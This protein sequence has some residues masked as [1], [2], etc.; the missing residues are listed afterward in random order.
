MAQWAKTINDGLRCAG[1]AQLRVTY[2]RFALGRSS[3]KSPH[4]LRG[5]VCPLWHDAVAPS[6]GWLVCGLVLDLLGCELGRRNLELCCMARKR[7]AIVFCVLRLQLA[8]TEIL[9]VGIVQI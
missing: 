7:M 8:Y 5:M 3:T 1:M 2:V 6:V 4:V 9:A